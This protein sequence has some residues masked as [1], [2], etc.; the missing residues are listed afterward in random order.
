MDP[1]GR[2]PWFILQNILS[3]LS[4]LPSLHRLHNA[5][6]TIAA[7]LHKNNDLFAR[8]VEAI[9]GNPSCENGLLPHVQHAVR[10]IALVWTRRLERAQEPYTDILSVLN[11]VRE[12]P[13]YHYEPSPI[14]NTIPRSTPSAVLCRLLGLMTRLRC[15]SHTCFHSMIAR[16]LELRIEHLPKKTK[17]IN[18]RRVVERDRRP[19]GISYIPVDIGPPT[20]MEQQRLLHSLLCVV[21]FYELRKSHSECSAITLKGDTIQTILDDNVEGFWERILSNFD[22]G[23][24]EQITVLLRWLDEQAGSRANVF[25]WIHSGLIQERYIYCCG[26]FTSM[27]DEQWDKAENDLFLSG[28]SRGSQCLEQCRNHPGSPLRFVNYSAFRPYGL[29]FWDCVRMDALG[30][31]GRLPAHRMWFAWSCILMEEDWKVLIE[32]Q[33]MR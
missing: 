1:F 19:Q 30:L 23:L 12:R 7:F 5:S 27:T 32:L 20:W 8:I 4:D 26:N 13:P 15:I 6:P 10:L 16:C 22:D 9:I 28:S 3:N 25:C 33:S 14:Q 21:F 18:T 17:Y 11:Y 2:F 29:V 24:V 31:S